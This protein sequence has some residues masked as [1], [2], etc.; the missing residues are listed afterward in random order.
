[1]IQAA[2]A[3]GVS[4][5][6]IF[7]TGHSLGGAEAE[8]VAAN[9]GLDGAT[10]GAPGVPQFSSTGGNTNLT[11]YVD[12]GDAV[13]NLASDTAPG[14]QLAGPNMNHVGNVVMV[15][16]IADQQALLDAGYALNNDTDGTAGRYVLGIMAGQLGDHM[17]GNYANDLGTPLQSLSPASASSDQLNPYNLLEGLDLPMGATGQQDL[18]QA[19]IVNGDE[20]TSP[21][22]TITLNGDSNISVTE[23]QPLSFGNQSSTDGTTTLDLN[24]SNLDAASG[25][26]T[27]SSGLTYVDTETYNADGTL[28]SSTLTNP[29]GSFAL[30]N[31]NTNEPLAETSVALQR[32][33]LIVDVVALCDL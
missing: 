19:S 9:L 17:L 12:Y 7:V 13:R 1:M 31:F 14:A 2:A 5:D 18:S 30:S 29:D 23:N 33:R 27:S 24:A 22:F 20:V 16:N 11:D 26:F 15:G 3:Q 32:D 6:N 25:S 8:S 28:V 4:T 10:F 21:D